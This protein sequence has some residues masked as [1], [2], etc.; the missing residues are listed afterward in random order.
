MGYRY[1]DDWKLVETAFF[2]KSGYPIKQGFD[3][4]IVSQIKS[5]LEKIESF[6]V[7]KIVF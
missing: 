6:E 4:S 2:E 3:A 1:S 7:R 5:S